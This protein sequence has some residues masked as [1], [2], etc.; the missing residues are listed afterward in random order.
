[1]R[2][3]SAVVLSAILFVPTFNASELSAAAPARPNI[4]FIMADDMGLGDLGAYNKKSKVP[5][6][7]MNRLAREGMRFLDAHSPSA[8]CTPTRYGVLTGRYAWRSRLKSGVLWGFSTSLIENGRTTVASM[9]KEQGYHTG[10]VGKWHLGFQQYDPALGEK[11][12]KVDYS[13]PLSPG[14]LSV[15]FDHFFGIPASLDM[16]PYVFV[17]DLSPLQ[18]PTKHIEKSLQ[19]RQGGKGFWRAGPI[20]PDFKHIDVLPKI[21]EKAVS[22]IDG[23][24]KDA[25]DG[26]PFFLYFPLS[27]PHTPWLPTKEFQGKSGAGAYGDFAAQVDWTVGQVLKALDRNQLSENTLVFLTSD[28]GAHWTPGDIKKY[29]HLANRHLRGQKA[30]TWEGGHRVPFLVRWPGVVKPGTVSRETICHTDLLATCA[31]VVKMELTNNEAED[32]Y[33]ILPV[34]RGDA[35][36]KPVR[37]ATVHHSVNG[38]FCI[39]QGDWKLILGLGSGGFSQPRT[40]KPKPN[41]PKGQLYNLSEDPSEKKNLY[42]AFPDIVEKLTKL[43]ERYQESGR[44]VKGRKAF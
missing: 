11:E 20:A 22:Y 6:P 25:K 40:V 19:A 21:T 33:S 8:V 9:L 7:N 31:D 5:T 12:Q 1:M 15:G 30:D 13:E 23:R 18:Q 2:F 10:A 27:A 32:S 28:N 34:L 16:E 39:R 41:G 4:V 17:E 38:T 29:G 43:L 42:Q 35:L 44:S 36:K 37:E 26:K 24:A 3:L 14:P